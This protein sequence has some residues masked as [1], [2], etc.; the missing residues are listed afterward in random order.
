MGLG[1]YLGSRSTTKGDDDTH[2]SNHGGIAVAEVARHLGMS[3]SWFKE[4][5]KREGLRVE[6]RGRQPGVYWPDVEEMV[7]RASLDPLLE[8]IPNHGT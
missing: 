1:S 3:P 7:G 8:K 6:R 4:L 2:L 5:A